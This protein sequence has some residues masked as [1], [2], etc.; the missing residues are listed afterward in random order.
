MVCFCSLKQ[1]GLLSGTLGAD[2][3]DFGFSFLGSFLFGRMSRSGNFGGNLL[4]LDG[5]FELSRL[6]GHF[7]LGIHLLFLNLDDFF[8]CSFGNGLLGSIFGVGSR[9]LG[10]YLSFFLGSFFLM[11]NFLYCSSGF[12]LFF[13]GFIFLFLS[14]ILL[15]QC[16]NVNF[17]GGFFWVV[18]LSF[19]T[20]FLGISLSL[21]LSSFSNFLDGISFGLGGSCK[22][23]LRSLSCRFN[24]FFSSLLG[25]ISSLSS[26]FGLSLISLLL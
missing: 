19:G 12:F 3:G 25:G 14:L 5:D 11:S 18:V 21:N 4:L 24:T 26:C 2:I 16:S 22:S 9:I 23:G 13:L 7:L 17:V 8:L 20:G 6:L 10:G 1:F 15:L